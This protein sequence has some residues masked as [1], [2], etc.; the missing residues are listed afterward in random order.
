MSSEIV[1]LIENV[2]MKNSEM[3]SAF[4][5]LKGFALKKLPIKPAYAIKK[6]LEKLGAELKVYT[7]QKFEIFKEYCELDEDGSLKPN[8]EGNVIFKE[9][10]DFEDFGKK[11]EELNSIE[12]SIEIR[13]VSL[14]DFGDIDV[15][16]TEING[17]E[18]M[19]AEG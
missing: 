14:A 8:E 5:C 17:I 11:M 3:E 16:I 9:D 2:T 19:L 6:N 12:N 7:E 13:R 10:I 4:N 1:G 18:F 15:D